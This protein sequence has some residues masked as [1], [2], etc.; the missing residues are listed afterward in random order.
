MVYFCQQFAGPNLGGTCELCTLLAEGRTVPNQGVQGRVIDEGAIGIP[1]LLVEVYDHDVLS[2]DDRLGNP[3]VDIVTDASGHYSVTYPASAYG[4]EAN[5]DIYVRVYDKVKRLLFVSQ[6]HKNVTDTTFSFPDIVIHRKDA[7]GWLATL[8]TGTPVSLTTGNSIEFLVD[9]A[10]AWPAFTAAVRKATSFVNFMQLMLDVNEEFTDFPVGIDFNRAPSPGDYVSLEGELLKANQAPR[11][12]PVRITVHDFRHLP[13]PFDT[14]GHVDDYFTDNKNKPNTA[15]VHRFP[16]PLFTPMHAKLLSVDGVECFTI[17]SPFLQ[18]YFDTSSHKI[19]NPERGPMNGPPIIRGFQHAITVPIHDVSCHVKGPAVVDMNDA[20]VLHYNVVR[21][22]DPALTRIAVPPVEPDN[23][24]LQVLRTVKGGTLFPT[25]PE[26][27]TG[28][29]EAYL[30]AIRNAK[31][32][33]YIE[34]QYLS[35]LDIK[36]ALLR[37]LQDPARANLQVILLINNKVDLPMYG[38]WQKGFLADLTTPLTDPQ[39]ARLGVFSLW[40][41]E[42][43]NPPDNPK[44]RIMRNYVHAKVA[45][46]D[47]VWATV[48]SANLDMVSLKNSDYLSRIFEDVLL[49]LV[50]FSKERGSEANVVMYQGIDGQ[51]ATTDVVGRLL[52][53]LWSEHLGFLGGSL[54]ARPAKGWLDLWNQ[55]ANDKING[56]QSS[57][58]APV[59]ARI[60]PFP[61]DDKNN[62]TKKYPDPDDYLGAIRTAGTNLPVKIDL[63]KFGIV[64]GVRAFSFATGKWK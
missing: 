31:D 8:G 51:P 37:S 50:D 33:I 58:G 60:L 43:A 29:L 12:L 26:G 52:R 18:E 41:H 11:N 23:V 20:F 13:Y 22:A 5:P 24:A 45:I 3:K 47:D 28:I 34:D 17:G 1:G 14:A 32:Y 9:N 42:A 15:N 53:R 40:T 62:I 30:R 55:R 10:D 6:V 49:E 35:C 2:A 63:T 44:P 27:E 39:K 57:P 16:M 7:E 59:T 21:G 56:L 25:L 4:L 46:V 19:D 54:P 61:H 36:E 48:G 38:I 64:E